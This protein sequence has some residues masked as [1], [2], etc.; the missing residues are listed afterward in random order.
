VPIYFFHVRGG[1]ADAEDEEGIAH[2]DEAA[3]RTFA[4]AGARSLI[5]GD[6]VEGILD[7]SGRID[8]EDEAGK[9]VFSLPFEKAVTRS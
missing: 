6:V 1:R 3:A 8:V 9:L 5:A 7:L 4:L 2:P